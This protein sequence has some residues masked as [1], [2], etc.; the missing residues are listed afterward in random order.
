[1][2]TLSAHSGAQFE[3]GRTGRPRDHRRL[4]E[5]LINAR[6]A[7]RRA[8][9]RQTEMR[10]STALRQPSAAPHA[11]RPA[12]SQPALENHELSSVATHARRKTI[13]RLSFGSRG[14]A[15][16]SWTDGWTNNLLKL[17]Q[18]EG[19]PTAPYGSWVIL[20]KAS[21]SDMEEED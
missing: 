10:S 4:V 12:T 18:Y 6:L 14:A 2:R 16:R 1:M 5:E 7:A 19:G 9:A 3:A 21:G 17:D 20:T 8:P 15:K 11:R 13:C